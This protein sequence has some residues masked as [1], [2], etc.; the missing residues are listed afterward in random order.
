MSYAPPK[1]TKPQH[2]VMMKYFSAIWHNGELHIH[3]GTCNTYLVGHEYAIAQR[4]VRAG[5]LSGAQ[6]ETKHVTPEG[7][8]Y[9]AYHVRNR[10]IDAAVKLQLLVEAIAEEYA[11]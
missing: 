8:R 7:K 6:W 3:F 4:L 1:L 9:I 2:E 10:L 5:L 11:S